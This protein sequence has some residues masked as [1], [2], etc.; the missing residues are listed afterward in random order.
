MEDY[1]QLRHIYSSLLSIV[2]VL[3]FPVAAETCFESTCHV[4][5]DG[6]LWCNN[7][8]ISHSGSCRSCEEPTCAGCINCD[9][10]VS[11]R[12]GDEINVDEEPFV[13][14]GT[15]PLAAQYY[16]GNT[17]GLTGDGDGDDPFGG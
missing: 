11:I 6:T 10:T 7:Q 13:R 16:S 12:A 3:A 4:D 5:E 15:E 2:C 8:V 1:M 14:C 17:G 9:Y